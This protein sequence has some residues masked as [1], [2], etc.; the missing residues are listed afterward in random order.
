PSSSVFADALFKLPSPS[1]KAPAAIRRTKSTNLLV[2]GD[3][4]EQSKPR[5][6]SVN[7]QTEKEPSRRLMYNTDRRS[8]PVPGN[9]GKDKS[10]Q[11]KTTRP[12][13][14]ADNDRKG[15]GSKQTK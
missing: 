12:S 15:G 7:R 5:S 10:K 9:T 1:S 4:S 6:S 13:P 14:T 3:K 8:S 11:T 2:E